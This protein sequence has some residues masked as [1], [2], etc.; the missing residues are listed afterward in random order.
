MRW[1]HGEP[2]LDEMLSDPTVITMMQRDDVKPDDVRLLV[3][4]MSRRLKDRRMHRHPTG[5]PRSPAPSQR[6]MLE[7]FLA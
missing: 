2:T 5:D 7:H 1:L 3:E 4:K 6:R